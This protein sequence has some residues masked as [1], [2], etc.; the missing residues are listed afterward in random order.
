MPSGNGAIV[1][2]M[3]T[4]AI[5]NGKILQALANDTQLPTGTALTE[6]GA[7]TTDP[8]E[9][10]VLLPLGGAKGSGLALMFEMLASVLAA[11]P[12]QALALG[13]QKQADFRA[14][15]RHSRSRYRQLPPAC[16][17]RE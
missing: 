5:S 2:D 9:A 15:Q 14:K 16:R 8:A 13:P 17:F 4:S 7:P 3:A 11:A 10:K 12:I 1:L 6:D